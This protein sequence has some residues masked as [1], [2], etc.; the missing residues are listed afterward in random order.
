MKYSFSNIAWQKE[1]DTEV[2]G[3][4]ADYGFTG[5][6]IAPTRIFPVRPYQCLSEAKEWSAGIKSKYGFDISSMQSIWYGKKEKLFGSKAQRD[7]LTQYTKAAILFAEAIGCRNLVFG[8]PKKR[9]LP[10]NGDIQEGL[11][12][13]REVAEFAEEHNTVIGLEANPAIYGTNYINTTKEALALI[14]EINCPGL[15]L[16]L[17]V[18]TMI[19]N[20]EDVDVVFDEVYLIN[21]VHISEPYLKPIRKQSFHRDLLNCLKNEGYNGYVSV[22]MG[23]TDDLKAVLETLE[24]IKELAGI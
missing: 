2:Y 18:G 24:Y 14:R 3:M 4:L 23:S 11:L 13:F 9:S 1:Q 10:E 15:R 7:A 21:H 12:F 20:N 22:E 19:A 5:L 8:S 6:E 17:D 16:N